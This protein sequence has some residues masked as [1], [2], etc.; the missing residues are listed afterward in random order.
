[1]RAFFP[2]IV[3]L[4]LAIVAVAVALIPDPKSN[5]KAII[6]VAGLVG[7]ALTFFS[8]YLESYTGRGLFERAACFV[9]PGGLYCK[10]IDVVPEV[11]GLWV[12]VG[13]RCEYAMRVALEPGALIA[14]PSGDDPIRESASVTSDGIRT[15]S[16]TYVRRGELLVLIGP[17]GEETPFQACPE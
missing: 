16:G 14:T 8:Y 11:E 10:E 17:E 1:M 7:V 6:L 5:R 4:L 12:G 9:F 3:G 2:E 15:V 13:Q